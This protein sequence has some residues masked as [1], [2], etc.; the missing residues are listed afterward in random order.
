MTGTTAGIGREPCSTDGRLL[1]DERDNRY[2]IG[3]LLR[4]GFIR[5]GKQDGEKIIESFGQAG[6][7]VEVEVAAEW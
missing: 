1:L 3:K 6:T 5:P 4:Y 7:R 2:F